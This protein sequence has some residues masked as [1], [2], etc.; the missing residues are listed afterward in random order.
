MPLAPG[1]LGTH[2]GRRAGQPPTL[3]EVLILEGKPE[4][5]HAG[6]ARG[7]DQDVGGL[8]VPVDQPSAMGVMQ[9]VGDRGDQFRRIPEGRASLFH[10]DCQVASFDELRDDEAE[11]VFRAAHVVDRH[12]VG[13]V[14]LGENSGFDEKRFHILG[15]GDSFGVRHLDGDRAV[16]VI[17]VSQIDPSEPALTEPADDPVAPDL[18]GIAVRGATRTKSERLRAPVSERSFVSSEEPPE[19][20]AG[21]LR[22]AGFGAVFR[23]IH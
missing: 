15:A 12:D 9:G 16:E 7:V 13:M 10:P 4:I 19:P 11:P 18:G 22:A 3:A 5:G 6:F 14:Q 20:G 17:V 23:L 21:G 8:D 1:L 2:V